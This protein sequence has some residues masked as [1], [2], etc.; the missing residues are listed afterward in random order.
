MKIL[1]SG[2]IF[3][4]VFALSACSDW[5]TTENDDFL[6]D[7]D[8][9]VV[10]DQIALYSEKELSDASKLYSYNAQAQ[11]DRIILQHPVSREI[12]VCD[13][14]TFTK[15]GVISDEVETCARE[16]E[17]FGFVR[18]TNKPRFVNEDLDKYGSV[19]PY[20]LYHHNDLTPR[21]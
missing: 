19:Y 15:N 2:A 13:S 1:L 17:E 10:G 8:P 3:A 5:T 20:R 12:S 16:L 4:G 9:D 21:W 6:Y 18:V 14:K 7:E 11:E